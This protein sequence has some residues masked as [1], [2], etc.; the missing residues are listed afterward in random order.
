MQALRDGSPPAGDAERCIGYL[1]IGR[2]YD[3]EQS[4]QVLREFENTS[5]RTGASWNPSGPSAS[6]STFAAECT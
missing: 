3:L 6:P 5:R 1:V 4:P 2:N